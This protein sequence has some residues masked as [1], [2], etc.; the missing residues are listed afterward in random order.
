M[1]R[2]CWFQ[3]L[4]ASF[5]A[6]VFLCFNMLYIALAVAVSVTGQSGKHIVGSIALLGHESVF[7]KTS[8]A[9]PSHATP[10]TTT[11]ELEWVV[12]SCAPL[13]PLSPTCLN[14]IPVWI[15]NYIH[16]TVWDEITYS[17][18]NFN[19][20]HTTL[21]QECDYLSMLGLKLNHV[22]KRGHRCP[23]ANIL[24]FTL[25]SLGNLMNSIYSTLGYNL[26]FD[27]Q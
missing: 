4:P 9:P 2:I 10:F 26:W 12:T 6:T 5:P 19:G 18:P 17:F 1:Q 20:A 27:L 8:K 24:T 25:I 7:R 22:S 13:C 16:Y 11:I 21:Y 3:N 14:L 15:S 23:A